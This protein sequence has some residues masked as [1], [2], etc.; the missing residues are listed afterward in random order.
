M[1]RKV[2]KHRI[3]PKGWILKKISDVSTTGSG[4]TPLSTCVEFYQG[5]TI[6]WINSG[7][8]GKL[9]IKSTTNFI[10]DAGIKNSSAK[11][12]PKGSVLL[13]MYGA[14]AGHASLLEIEAT[15]NQAICAIIPYAGYNAK[16]IKY[17]L[18]V[19]YQYLVGIS[20][21]SA[22]DNL[23][24]NGIQ[25]IEIPFPNE[26]IQI[27]I[28]KVLSCIDSKIELN[29]C[30]N[31][32]LEAMA[33][34]LYDYWFV[35]FDFPENNGKPYKSSG[36]KMVWN[37]ELKREIPEEW[38][39]GNASDLFT[40]NP[41]LSLKQGC[42][43]SYIDMNALPTEGFMTKEVQLKEFKGGVKFQNSD[44]VVA[45]ITPCLENGKTGLITLLKDDDIGFG[46]TE[47]IVLRGRTMKLSSFAACL[48]RSEL[49]RKYAIANMT[50]T[51]GRKRVDTSA[52][53]IFPIAI[54]HKELLVK[55]EEAVVPFF[56]KTTLNTKENQQLT[57]LRD[58]LLPMLMNGQVKVK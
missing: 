5:G 12:F 26:N 50:G 28:A 39:V 53:E 48:S 21:G 40:F 29:N 7:E 14:T 45:R 56:E 20:T 2:F 37:K 16:F 52:L 57:E 46:S 24:Q 15:T 33:K 11:F 47:F 42:L 36:G 22:R 34:T 58:W 35:Q 44:L 27:K 9:S 13:A 51:S 49:F 17:Y 18:D 23:N 38:E 25:E 6:P 55:F 43:C 19:L 8:V 54:P 3:I 41:S 4:G 10:T 31:A 1:S 30:I 32:E